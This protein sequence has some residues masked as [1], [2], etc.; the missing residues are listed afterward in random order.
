MPSLNHA[1]PILARLGEGQE[2]A[3]GMK[4]RASPDSALMGKVT[5]GKTSPRLPTGQRLQEGK[6]VRDR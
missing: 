6:V 5:L 4:D 3:W 1:A 2:G